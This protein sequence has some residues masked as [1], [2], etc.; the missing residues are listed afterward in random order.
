MIG[1]D[2]TV[3]RNDPNTN[4]SWVGR[5]RVEGEQISIAW[6]DFPHNR[7]L[8]K[9]NEQSASP[10]FNVY[11]PM[12]QCAGKRFSGKYNWGLAGSGQYMQFFPDGT[13]IDHQ[14]LDQMLVPSPYYD[15]PRTQRGTYAIQS[16]TMIFTFVDGR[17]GMRTFYAPKVQEQAPMFDWIGLGWHQLYEEHYKSQP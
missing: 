2:F 6:Q 5:Y 17:R 1:F 3:C 7:T 12:C 16:Q 10:G 13:F 15:D 11:V 8:I 9:R 14:V 4:R